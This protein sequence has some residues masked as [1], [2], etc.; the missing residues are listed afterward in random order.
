MCVRLR[1]WIVRQSRLQPWTVFS[2]G[3]AHHFYGKD[4]LSACF[5]LVAPVL[6]LLALIT[7]GTFSAKE[8]EIRHMFA[9]NRG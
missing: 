2:T 3:L 6:G 7:N 9:Y 8:P 5:Q 4:R 1:S